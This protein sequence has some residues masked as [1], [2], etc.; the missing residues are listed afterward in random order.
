[1]P[2]SEAEAD[3]G[4]GAVDQ[5]VPTVHCVLS[6]QGCKV[7]VNSQEA[8]GICHAMTCPL[9]ETAGLLCLTTLRYL[10]AAD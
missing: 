5:A 10:G 8:F 3:L 2:A 7:P 4:S 1:M 6:Q 9:I